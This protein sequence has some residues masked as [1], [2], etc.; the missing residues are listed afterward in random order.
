MWNGDNNLKTI[1]IIGAGTQGAMI[2]YRNAYYGKTV[3]VS[4]IS[5]KQIEITK[6]KMMEWANQYIIAG[7]LIKTQVD[8]LLSRIHYFTTADA[9]IRGADLIIENV[10]ENVELK[11]RVWKEIGECA[12]ARAIIT[13][14]SSS[15]KCS[16][17]NI[18]VQ[19]KD[20]TFNLNFTDPINDDFIEV[21]WNDKTSEE[22][23]REVLLYLSS[24]NLSP[25]VTQKEIQGFSVNRL[26]RAMKK[27]CLHLWANDITDPADFDAAFVR[28]WNSRSG[29][30]R[31]M[32]QV[33]LD[34]VYDIE[35]SYYR[36]TQNP[37]DIPPKRL[38]EW[39]EQG[40][41]GVKSGEGF[42]KY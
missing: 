24:L 12:D 33:G 16:L 5:E 42:Y 34:V 40:R 14:N 25:L 26:W 28:E 1:T 3:N 37:S 4:D 19:Q 23:K 15:I 20:K 27:E 36:E 7:K 11:R 29:P 30:F 9:A 13:T 21:M 10:P 31:F 41:L 38:K 39:V 2:S 35:M 17:I 8:D 6:G 18:D 22:T 32:D